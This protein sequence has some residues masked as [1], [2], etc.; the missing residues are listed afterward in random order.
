[1]SDEKTTITS[2]AICNAFDEIADAKCVMDNHNARLA[3]A[4]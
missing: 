3:A 2:H 4:E 1:M